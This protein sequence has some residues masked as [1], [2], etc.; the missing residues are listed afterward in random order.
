M[1]NPN[2]TRVVI[3]PSQNDMFKQL[4]YID[5]G[6]EQ[7]FTLKQLIAMAMM[8]SPTKA[9]WSNEIVN[10]NLE[11]FRYHAALYHD[12]DCH[13]RLGSSACDNPIEE[14]VDWELGLLYAPFKYA[15]TE[16]YSI[17]PGEEQ[18]TIHNRVRSHNFPILRL[19]LELRLMVYKF[20]LTFP[21]DG[22][23]WTVRGLHRFSGQ[24]NGRFVPEADP[25]E[26]LALLSVSRQI[27]NE[28]MGIFYSENSFE[29]SSLSI[30]WSFLSGIGKKKRKFLRHLAFE[31]CSYYHEQFY[32]DKRFAPHVFKLFKDEL[33][34]RS[35]HIDIDEVIILR[36]NKKFKGPQS[37]PGFGNLIQIRSLKELTFG[38]SFDET[39]KYLEDKMMGQ[40]K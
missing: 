30:L 17:I 33:T 29:F 16:G 1:S 6:E 20:A 32:S 3:T 2:A 7:P 15:A 37:F 21:C 19:P 28:A 39:K 27:Y 12:C 34:L 35:L 11:N 40:K 13:L 9:L 24:V 36:R 38:G 18:D 25:K 31:Y 4:D 14:D 5:V 8:S 23:R 22:V 10:W 26:L